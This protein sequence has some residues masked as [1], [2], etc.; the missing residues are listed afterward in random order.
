MSEHE[1][2]NERVSVLKKWFKHFSAQCFLIYAVLWFFVALPTTHSKRRERE[3]VCS[4]YCVCLDTPESAFSPFALTWLKHINGSGWIIRFHFCAHK[5]A[6]YIRENVP[7]MWSSGGGNG[8]EMWVKGGLERILPIET[9]GHVSK[10]IYVI[11]KSDLMSKW[12]INKNY[13]HK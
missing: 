7:Y 9:I 6:I 5:N 10:S 8:G 4:V 3:C 2:S 13:N 12:R 1:E 11:L